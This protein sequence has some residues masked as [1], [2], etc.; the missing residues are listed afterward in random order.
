[1]ERTD[2]FKFNTREYWAD[3]AVY[4]VLL[5]TFTYCGDAMVNVSAQP[6][7][8]AFLFF[9]A[10]FAITDHVMQYVRLL[11]VWPWLRNA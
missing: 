4:A 9:L 3:L 1:M 10:L 2:L 8:W 6:W 5:I 11:R 7:Y